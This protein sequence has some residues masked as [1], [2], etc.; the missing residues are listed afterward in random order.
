MVRVRKSALP[1]QR[2]TQGNA[3]T[4]N[5]CAAFDADSLSFVEGVISF[6]FDN[7]IY[8]H[9]SVKKQLAQEQHGKCCYCE[10]KFD[11]AAPGDV[12]HF[13]PKMG[14][15]Q[16][17]GHPLENPG[18][19]WLAYTWSN[20]YFS[21]INCNRSGKK[22]FFPLK[23]GTK[24]ARIHTDSIQDEEPL[25]LDPGGLDNPRD[26]I[27]FHR[28]VA[29]GVT[30]RGRQTIKTLK[31]DRESLNAERRDEFKRLVELKKLVTAFDANPSQ[32]YSNLAKSA[33]RYL[34]EAVKPT[35]KFSAMAQD[36]LR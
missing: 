11:A 12:E 18:Y 10:N 15:R 17:K 29:F 36:L 25:L 33:R 9:A 27:H 21:C 24:R 3:A 6:S 5:N 16:D 31:L 22:S 30:P 7:T 23:D 8:G 35:A 20:L 28:E 1:P 2:L 32:Q 26:H 34:E 19:Y 4:Q 14:V 13:R